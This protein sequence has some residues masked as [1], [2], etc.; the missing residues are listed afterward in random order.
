M[1]GTTPI[2]LFLAAVLVVQLT[3]PQLQSDAGLRASFVLISVFVASWVVRDARRINLRAYATS[4]AWRPAILFLVALAMWMV[5]L[6]WYLTVRESIEA[7]QVPL[8]PVASD[9]G[10][11]GITSV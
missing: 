9:A 4:L 1:K 7:G 3:V 6:P 5:V 10:R 8:R 11:S 2:W